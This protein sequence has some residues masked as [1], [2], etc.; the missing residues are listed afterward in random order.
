M[1]EWM[2]ARSRS[3]LSGHGVACSI[4]HSR[5]SRAKASEWLLSWAP[6]SD[7]VHY[8]FPVCIRPKKRKTRSNCSPPL[9]LAVG[10][11]FG[12]VAAPL[13]PALNFESLPSPPSNF[14]LPTG[15]SALRL[16]DKMSK[17]SDT[18]EKSENCIA[19][20]QEIAERFHFPSFFTFNYAS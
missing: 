3:C 13:W 7:F 20:R 14:Q 9:R 6:R 11:T 4:L 17:R 1:N 16:F 5:Y 19:G 18:A 2:P 10:D 12:W 8:A 15:F